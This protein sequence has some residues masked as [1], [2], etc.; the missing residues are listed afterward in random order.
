VDFFERYLN[1]S[2]DGGS[3]VVEV[4][5]AT[6]IILLSTVF[7]CRSLIVQYLRRLIGFARTL[8]THHG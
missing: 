7:V 4:S 2:P 5:Y 3:G 8:R 6:I 1:L